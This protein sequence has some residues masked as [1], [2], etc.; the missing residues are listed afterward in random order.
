MI[1]RNVLLT[2]VDALIV[3]GVMNLTAYLMP[4]ELSISGTY[5][6]LIVVGVMHTVREENWRR[7]GKILQTPWWIG[8]SGLGLGL[9]IWL[10][11]TSP[12]SS[13]LHIPLF[14]LT[15]LMATI[16]MHSIL[17]RIMKPSQ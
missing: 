8:P 4:L 12:S 3:F 6:F 13:M 17:K 11:R 5:F 10:L 14:I 2:F 16:I 15:S 9:G 1:L 7:K